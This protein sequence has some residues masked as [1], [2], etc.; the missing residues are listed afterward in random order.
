MKERAKEREKERGKE[1]VKVRGKERVK[2]RVKERGKK[3][4]KEREGER[5]KK[6][7][8][9]KGGGKGGGR[10][11]DSAVSRVHKLRL[12]PTQAIYCNQHLHVHVMEYM[13]VCT[14]TYS[15]YVYSVCDYKGCSQCISVLLKFNTRSSVALEPALPNMTYMCS[16]VSCTRTYMYCC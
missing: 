15:P 4:G 2:E 11:S 1:R 3:R 5:D 6:S 14:C 10:K 9:G 16:E 12:G 7:E 13:H 8:R